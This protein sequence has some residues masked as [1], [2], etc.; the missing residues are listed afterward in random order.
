V[1]PRCRGPAPPRKRAAASSKG[2]GVSAAQPAAPPATMPRGAPVPPPARM[3]PHARRFIVQPAPRIFALTPFWRLFP[4]IAAVSALPPRQEALLG[5]PCLSSLWCFI[6]RI[7]AARLGACPAAGPAACPGLLATA[8]ASCGL[9]GPLAG[10]PSRFFQPLVHHPCRGGRHPG[11]ARVAGIAWGQPWM[12]GGAWGGISRL[13][14]PP[15]PKKN[16][17]A[18]ALHTQPLARTLWW[19]PRPPSPRSDAFG[20]HGGT[21]SLPLPLQS[22]CPCPLPCPVAPRALPLPCTPLLSSRSLLLQQAHH[23]P[24]LFHPHFH[25]E[26]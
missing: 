22:T 2:I 19:T 9:A 11:R 10:C 17:H 12:G 26:R 6:A 4:L 21:A 13:R 20:Q 24:A 7:I 8:E 25:P 5:I 18:H 16:T 1:T 3:H 23:R 15:P 14:P